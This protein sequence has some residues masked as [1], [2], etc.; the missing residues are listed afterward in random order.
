MRSLIPW[1]LASRGVLAILLLVAAGPVAG[2]ERIPVA[3]EVVPS[4]APTPA[5]DLRMALGRLLGEHAY[6][7]M[8]A[9]R[10]DADA[11]PDAPALTNGLDA[12]SQALKDAFASVYGEAAG[13]AFEPIWQRHIDASTAYAKA[14]RAGDAT[15]TR[16]ALDELSAF[17][18][19]FG[20]FLTGANPKISPDAEVHAM[21]LHLDQL[22]S[23]LE[24]DYQQAFATQRA[25]YS[26][27][28]DFGDEIARAIVAQFPDRFPDGAV[29]FSP[30][31][32]LRLT[33]GRLLGEHLVLA[34][35]AMRSGLVQG[36]DSSAAVGSIGQNSA[37]LAEAIGR[38]FGADAR[39]AFAD[40]WAR[41]IET[42]LQY[43]DAVRAGDAAGRQSALESLHGY[44]VTL[45][46][47]LHDAIPD[48]SQADVEALISHHVT[49]LINQVDAAAAGDEERAVTVTREAYGQ[50]FVVGDALGNG[51]ADE[52]PD[53]FSDVEQIPATNT[54]PE[55][56]IVGSC[57]IH[58]SS[59]EA[60]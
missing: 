55:Q 33:L 20:E 30:R 3:P 6:L 11:A 54:E 60:D 42:Y 4:A 28:F 39:D 52:F 24:N 43:I 50:M 17:S 48:L 40:V 27:M 29:A 8:S 47:F 46:K 19:Q 34:A 49:A 57:S 37:D 36:A 22:T 23:F 13:A 35:A 2:S 59:A 5:S 9:M 15:G 44:H 14:A 53:R 7:L 18:K 45:A 56:D 26:H 38:I 1:R 51:I 16:A 32:T 25:A 12:N 21:Q 58:S 10:A 41:H 31:T